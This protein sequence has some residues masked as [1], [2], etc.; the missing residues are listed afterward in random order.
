VHYAN[1]CRRTPILLSLRSGVADEVTACV[2][3]EQFPG[4]VEA[5]GPA[6]RSR[7]RVDGEILDLPA[8]TVMRTLPTELGSTGAKRVVDRASRGPGQ[9]KMS[10][11]SSAVTVKFG[12]S[13]I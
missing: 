9:W 4:H 5:V 1:R 8:S 12:T 6:N 3:E 11:G 7:L 2:G 13:T 10:R